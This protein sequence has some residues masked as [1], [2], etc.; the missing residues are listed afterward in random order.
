MRVPWHAHVVT[1]WMGTAGWMTEFV[2]WFDGPL[3]LND[4]AWMRGRVVGKE[5]VPGDSNE[6][7]VHL[8]LDAV[9]FDGA[10]ISHGTATVVL[11]CR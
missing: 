9:N 10:P 5:E 6:G 11:P 4:T 2:I 3:F 8:E 7:V 1:D